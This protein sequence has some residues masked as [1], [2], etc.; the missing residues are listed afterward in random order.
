MISHPRVSLNTDRV[1][2]HG[3]R[4]TFNQQLL[5]H[6]SIPFPVLAWLCWCVSLCW[7]IDFSIRNVWARG[8]SNGNPRLSRTWKHFFYAHSRLKV[9][10]AFAVAWCRCCCCG[11]LNST[12][13]LSLILSRKCS[14]S[15]GCII[16]FNNN[17]IQKK[18]SFQKL[19]CVCK[20]WKDESRD[21]RKKSS[22]QFI[23]NSRF[24]KS[25]KWDWVVV[26]LFKAKNNFQTM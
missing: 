21:G 10:H 26:L 23:V 16:R 25:S 3:A 6:T 11:T 7:L 9:Q 4:S 2:Y 14:R 19:C 18:E 5:Q 20:K 13:I 8:L 24:F 1:T 22:D 12:H 17:H 15:V